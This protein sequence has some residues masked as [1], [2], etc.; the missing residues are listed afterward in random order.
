LGG[1]AFWVGVAIHLPARA[2]PNAVMLLKAV[3]LLSK[4]GLVGS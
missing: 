4:I 1:G 2:F 3:L